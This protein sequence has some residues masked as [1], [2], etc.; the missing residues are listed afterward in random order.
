MTEDVGT[1]PD[2]PI[3]EAPRDGVPDIIDTAEGLD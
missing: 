2:V 3:L 1:T